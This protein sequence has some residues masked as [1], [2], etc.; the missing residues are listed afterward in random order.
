MTH[1]NIF[2]DLNRLNRQI[3]PMPPLWKHGVGEVG[4]FDNPVGA[5]QGSGRNHLVS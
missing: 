2:S 1:R 5:Q 4:K 3:S